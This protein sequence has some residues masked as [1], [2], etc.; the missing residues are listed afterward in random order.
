M[1]GKT[2]RR[3]AIA[4]ETERPRRLEKAET[5]TQRQRCRDRDAEIVA[6]KTKLHDYAY[7]I[8]AFGIVVCRLGTPKWTC[9][10]RYCMRCSAFFTQRRVFLPMESAPCAVAQTNGMGMTA[11]ENA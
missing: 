1:G 3:E 11:V 4:R 9:R 5:A 2:A 10:P 8:L 6:G 7:S